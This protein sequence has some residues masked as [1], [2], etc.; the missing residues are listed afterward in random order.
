[1][2][3]RERAHAHPSRAIRAYTAPTN[4]DVFSSQYAVR[5]QAAVAA[6]LVGGVGERASRRWQSQDG[7]WA[8]TS[9]NV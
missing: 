2:V 4:E 8:P 5:R 1:M 7:M 3:G 6:G 9:L